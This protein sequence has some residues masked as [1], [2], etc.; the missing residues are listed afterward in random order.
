MP[1]NPALL[2]QHAGESINDLI[3]KLS[4]DSV[5]GTVVFNATLVTVDALRNDATTASGWEEELLQSR[6]SRNVPK[7]LKG[8]HS[9]TRDGRHHTHPSVLEGA[10]HPCC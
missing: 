1:S 5:C 10:G 9:R 6:K 4:V 3:D 7:T 8:L 2:A